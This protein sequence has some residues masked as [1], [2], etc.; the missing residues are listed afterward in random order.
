MKQVFL[1]VVVILAAA[2][3][4]SAQTSFY[5]PHVVNGPQGNVVWKTTIL[6]TNPGSSATAS[7]S[8]G[9]TSDNPNPGAAGSPM[10]LTMTDENGQSAT[11][12]V[13]TFSL[14][15]G[16]TRRFIS[17]GTGQ[18]AQGFATV[19][20]DNPVSGT[21]IFSEFDTAGNLLGEAGVPAATAVARQ[22]IFV[23][24]VANYKIGVAY[25]NPGPGAATVSLNL[26]DSSG[27]SVL[28]T[29]ATQTLGPGNHTAAF[30]FQMFPSAPNMAGTMQLVSNTP[31]AAIALRFDPPLAKF[32]TL[33]PVTLASV[34]YPFAEWIQQRLWLTPLSSVATLLGA[35][36]LSIG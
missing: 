5:Y 32:T 31:L 6:L 15:P 7:G 36:Q 34:F 20:T 16:G 9:F 14:P 13:F 21:A 25:A 11:S 26:L 33:P 10:T 19:T 30:T 18:F 29:P 23:D 27:I 1:N 35:L 8:V 28:T 24:T 17:S 12:S 4:A 2:T 3:V 22:A